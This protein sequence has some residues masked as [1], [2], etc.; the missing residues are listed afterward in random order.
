[1]PG[2]DD[3]RVLVVRGVLLRAISVTGQLAPT[4]QSSS[5]TLSSAPSGQ[6]MTL[7]TSTTALRA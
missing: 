2:R 4:A 5:S 3:Y 7:A 6:R 1:M